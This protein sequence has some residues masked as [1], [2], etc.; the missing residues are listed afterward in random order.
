[1]KQRKVC[2][3]FDPVFAKDRAVA[4]CRRCHNAGRFDLHLNQWVHVWKG[5]LR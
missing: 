1:V 3:W 4:H 5:D 2:G